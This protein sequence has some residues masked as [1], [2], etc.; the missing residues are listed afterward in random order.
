MMKIFQLNSELFKVTGIQKVVMDIHEALRPYG[1]R[2]VG[3]IPFERVDKTLGIP[4]SEYVQLRGYGMFRNS[5]VIIHERRYLPVFWGLNKLLRYNVRVIYIHHSELYG[6]KLLSRFPREVVAISDAGIRNLTE[7]FGVPRSCITKIHNCVRE[8]VGMSCTPKNFSGQR[9]TI[10]Y[11]ARINSGKQQIEI[12]RRL[13]GRIDPRVRILFAGVGPEY[14]A[15]VR[16]CAGSQQFVALG[17]RSDVLQLMR[18]SDFMMLFSLYEGLPISL[19]EA[20]MTATPILCNS[21]GGNTEIA[22]AGKNAFVV[23]DW[24]ELVE[25]IN[26]L[27]ELSQESYV[28]MSRE[29]RRIYESEFRFERFAKEYVDL[30]CKFVRRK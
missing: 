23:A 18:E 3:T 24:D 6:Q 22:Y 10:L 26:L 17:F 14:D 2:I 9:V 8:P 25:Q 27:P 4:Q 11:P 30:I 20:T 19:I 16:E 29:S 1:A 21:V 7:Y 5:V 28:A 15:L 13:R 12:V